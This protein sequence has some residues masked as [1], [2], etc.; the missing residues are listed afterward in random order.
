M[1]VEDLEVYQGDD[2]SV[3][4]TVKNADGTAASLAGFVAK[5][6]VRKTSADFGVVVA[7]FTATI[8]ANVIALSLTN[9][10]TVKL[11]GPYYWDVQI[12]S[13]AGAV[14]TL[15]RGRLLATEEITREAGAEVVM[16]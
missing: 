9:A 1:L 12:K 10:Q 11:A 8:Q 15:A 7:E 16:V 4:V 6:Q 2:I 13:P 5:A 14:T 3:T